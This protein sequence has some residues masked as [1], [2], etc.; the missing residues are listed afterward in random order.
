[1]LIT[2]CS[3]DPNYT[4]ARFQLAVSYAHFAELLGD[5]DCFDKSIEIFQKL[6]QE[7]PED[8]AAYNE[9]GSALMNLSV[10]KENLDREHQDELQRRAEQAFLQA[11]SLGNQQVFYN[12]AC[13]YSLRKNLSDSF[14]F[15]KKAVE[16]GFIASIDDIIYD[17]WLE[18]VRATPFFQTYLQTIT[19]EKDSEEE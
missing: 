10:L 7:D 13:L 6:I 12:L 11:L 1:M 18:N 14:H 19:R 4:Q 8:D 2:A 3:I 15:F 16:S 5:S 9:Y 17:E